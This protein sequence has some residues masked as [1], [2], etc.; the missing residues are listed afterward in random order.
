MLLVRSETSLDGLNCAYELKLDGYRALGIKS[1]SVA[2]GSR[3]NRSFDGNYPAIVQYLGLLPDDT[4][5]DGEVVASFSV[6]STSMSG[7]RLKLK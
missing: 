6:S 1:Y 2:Q 3:N 5:I 4:V 7:N